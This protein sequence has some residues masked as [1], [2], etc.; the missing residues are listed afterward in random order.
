MIRALAY[1]VVIALLG[2]GAALYHQAPG[3]AA[4]ALLHPA[5]QERLP[6]TP[7]NCLAREF[8]GAGVLLRG[9]HCRAA[10]E[11]RGTIVYLHGIAD[12]RGSAIG[13]IAR[14]TRNGFDVVAYDS[15]AH[16]QSD[17]TA[18]TYGYYEKH[19]VRRVIERLP[20]GRI[21]I[22]GT[23]LGAAVALQAAAEEPRITG[24]VG[25]EVFSDLATIARQRA[26]VFVW[27]A[28]VRDAFAV[29]EQ[30]AA[31]DVESVSPEKAARNVRV[32]V[33]LLHGDSDTDTLPAHSRRVYEALAGPKR[34]ILIPGA[35]HNQ[36]L[37]SPEAW[38]EI[39]RWIDAIMR[40]V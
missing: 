2:G 34:L 37:G 20:A 32:P 36:T 22:V 21:A 30:Q 7:E 15:R 1:A 8:D 24:V 16:G 17:G 4:G 40:G 13:P 33:L 6:D 35:R 18:C 23:S 27:D 19:D 28:L 11:P 12:N 29:A 9:W 5:R 38:V 14:F 39:D 3:I 10:G 31:F 26:P 25:A